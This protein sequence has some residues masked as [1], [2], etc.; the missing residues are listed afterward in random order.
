MRRSARNLKAFRSGARLAVEQATVQQLEV[1][2]R[3][4]EDAWR[5]AEAA[6]AEAKYEA[7]KEGVAA[8]SC[9]SR[10]VAPPVRRRFRRILGASGPH[11]QNQS[12]CGGRVCVCVPP[13]LLKAYHYCLPPSAAS[14]RPEGRDS[15]PTPPPHETGFGPER[16]N[17]APWGA[18]APGLPVSGLCRR[19][20]CRSK[21]TVQVAYSRI[22]GA[23]LKRDVGRS[24]CRGS[25]VD[26]AESWARRALTT[27]ACGGA[28]E[29][30][31]VPRD[32]LKAYYYLPATPGPVPAPRR[33]RFR[34]H[35]TTARNV[36]RSGVRFRPSGATATPRCPRT[37]GGRLRRREPRPNMRPTRR[38]SQLALAFPGGLL[39]P[40]PVRRRFRRI[41]G[42]SCP[43]H[44]SL[45]GGERVCVS[46]ET[47]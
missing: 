37:R 8:G 19:C 2:R 44:Q 28:R 41:L 10:G 40:V 11:H 22:C 17:G 15:G 21:R 38:V 24:M 29:S 30:V 25:G 20:S 6:R 42:A 36:F 3:A 4:A 13:D 5:A 32:L 27:R 12:M 31:C 47:F 45:C 14:P 26:F 39:R 46:L 7:Y 34:S 23:D 16:R 33:A 18:D 35:S 9:L 1:D 43:H